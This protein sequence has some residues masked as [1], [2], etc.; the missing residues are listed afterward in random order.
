M[1]RKWSGLEKVD[2]LRAKL[3]IS[4]VL[5]TRYEHCALKMRL[6]Y[7]RHNPVDL[8]IDIKQATASSEEC[9]PE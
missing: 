5:S 6:I 8:E 9:G 7:E 1:D 4:N 2:V 3:M